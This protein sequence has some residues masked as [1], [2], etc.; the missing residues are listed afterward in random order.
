MLAAGIAFL[1]VLRSAG[2]PRPDNRHEY[3]DSVIRA[4]AIATSFWGVVGM[5]V[6]VVIASQ[7]A[8]PQLNFQWAEGY[9][10]FGR[11]RPL[12]TSAVI[13]AFGGNALIAL[14][15]LI[16]SSFASRPPTVMVSL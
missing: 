16:L 15:T 9:L 8:F 12:H 11:L 2:D 3:F 10:N 13:F 7:L 14:G 5:L 1:F 4:G 6:G